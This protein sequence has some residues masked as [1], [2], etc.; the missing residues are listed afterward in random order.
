VDDGEQPVGVPAIISHGISPVS[1]A[2]SL[3]PTGS[4]A[5][6]SPNLRS[7]VSSGS[8]GPSD[9]LSRVLVQH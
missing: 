7:S 2:D 5:I 3:Y 9:S 4:S 1:P 8:V 6:L